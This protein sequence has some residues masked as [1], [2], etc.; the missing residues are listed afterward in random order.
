MAVGFVMVA[1]VAACLSGFSALSLGASAAAVSGLC[2]GVL[3]PV[4][5]ATIKLFLRAD[6]AAGK[7]A[8]G[9]V[10]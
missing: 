4:A 9:P 8:D 10:Q 7:A 6:I 5:L 3:A 2:A 1:I